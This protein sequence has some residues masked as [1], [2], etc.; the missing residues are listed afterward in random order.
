MG[1]YAGRAC[2][3]SPVDVLTEHRA[4][5]YVETSD[6]SCLQ[7]YGPVPP[8]LRKLD[9]VAIVP[10]PGSVDSCTDDF[11]VQLFMNADGDLAAVSL[12]MGE[13]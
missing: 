13:P 10:A 11:A 7:T 6:S 4:V 1:E 5:A 12:L 2:P 3:L 8:D 9:R